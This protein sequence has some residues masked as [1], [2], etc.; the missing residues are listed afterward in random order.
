LDPRVRGNTVGAQTQLAEENIHF[1]P[2]NQTIEFLPGETNK[3]VKVPLI[4]QENRCLENYLTDA[5]KFEYVDPSG[6]NGTIS[7]GFNG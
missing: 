2:I 5:G 1:V 7:F 4:N 6:S 3:Q